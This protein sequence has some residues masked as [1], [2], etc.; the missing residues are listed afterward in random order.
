MFQI[1]FEWY[2]AYSVRNESFTVQ[3]EYE[4]AEGTV[5]QIYTK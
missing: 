1:D 2:I 4:I 3:D 5:F